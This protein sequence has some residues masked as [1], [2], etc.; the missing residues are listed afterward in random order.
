M[1]TN[2]LWRAV[3]AAA[4]ILGISAGL[5]WL[6]PAFV[7]TDTARRIVGAILGAVVVAYANVIPK[8]LTGRALRASS[9][10]ADQAAR[11]FVG[12]SM[13]SGGLGY[14]L[15]WSFAPVDSAAV[16]GGTLLGTALLVAI[17]RCV[18]LVTSNAGN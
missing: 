7:G 3:L 4:F 17:L 1:K 16:I 11:R 9:T 6:E 8:I 10:A 13:V 12:W 14:M 5:K 18:R 15:A 2:H